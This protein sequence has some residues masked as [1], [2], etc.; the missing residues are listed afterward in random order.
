MQSQSQL[1]PTATA[2]LKSLTRGGALLACLLALAL[3]LPHLGAGSLWYDETV[4]AYLASL[5]LPEAVAHTALDIHPPGYYLVLNLWARVAGS[6]EYSLAFLSVLFGVLLVALTYAVARRLGNNRGGLMAAWLTAGSAFAIWYSQEVR[7]YSLGG[8]L[9][10]LLVLATLW[11]LQRPS[12]WRAAGWGAVAAVGLYALYY[13]LFLLPVV[14]GYWLVQCLRRPRDRR[15]LGSWFLGHA[16][17]LTLYLPWLPLAIRQALDPPVPPWR[18]ALSLVS[19]LRDGALSLAF[20]EA[21]TPALWPV[22]LLLLL[23]ALSAP[24]LASKRGSDR[25]V[26]A[27]AGFAVPWAAIIVASL[28]VPLFHPRYLAPFVPFY[29]V[30]LA[31][32]LADLSSRRGWSGP[33]AALAIIF[34][35]GNLGFQWRT[36]T[37]PEFQADDLRAGVTRLAEEWV[38]GDAVLVNAG[39]TYTALLYYWPG[40]HPRVRITD[41]KASSPGTD[42]TLVMTG[43]LSGSPSLGWGHPRSDFYAAS[44]PETIA[45]LERLTKANRRLWV[46]R[47]YDTVV[48]PEGRVRAWLD[49]NL[50]QTYDYLLPGP[51][52]ARLQAYVPRL[53]SLPCANPVRWD[54]DVATCSAMGEPYGAGQV[55][56]YLYSQYQVGD[57]P[58]HYTLRL[59]GPDGEVEDQQDGLLGASLPGAEAVSPPVITQ[60]LSL[61]SQPER[62]TATYTV[63]M[64][65]YRHQDGTLTN[66]APSAPAT[67]WGPDPS[68]VVLGTVTL[69]R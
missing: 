67:L 61:A 12:P 11:V 48:D 66:L 64:G 45:G 36:W 46:F 33:A 31:W 38:P 25:K 16:V 32:A 4:S 1:H 27:V 37:A 69:G 15:S 42:L 18:S 5:P 14:S 29:L 2:R 49:D 59:L 24:L 40:P 10:C 51:S 63:V 41:Y 19:M 22:G 68:L 54:N 26:L 7:M 53:V 17:L 62:P 13:L 34:T 52:Y 39:Y 6:G 60:P 44:L 30:C 3:R 28:F 65:L 21:A 9:A 20:G 55:P 56:V 23:V 35:L 47:L 57:A 50:I 8:C 43:S 58:V